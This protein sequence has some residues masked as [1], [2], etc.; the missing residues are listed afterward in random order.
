[1]RVSSSAY[2]AATFAHPREQRQRPELPRLWHRDQEHHSNSFR[3]ETMNDVLLRRAHCIATTA[4]ACDFPSGT[5]FHRV[6]C[7]KH[8][9]HH[10]W[11]QPRDEQAHPDP[12]RDHILRGGVAAPLGAG[13]H[14]DIPRP[15]RWQWAYGRAFLCLEGSRCIRRSLLTCVADFIPSRTGKAPIF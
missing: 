1:M 8:D 4:L 5:P 13:V 10:R 14:R 9:R 15:Q 11:R 6:I 2:N 3:R 7:P 12:A